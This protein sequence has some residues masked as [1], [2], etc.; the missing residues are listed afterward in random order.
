MLRDNQLLLALGNHHYE[1]TPAGHR[2]LT[3]ELMLAK[4]ASAPPEPE[5]WLQSHGWQL[6]E[7]VNERVRAALAMV[8]LSGY[9]ERGIGQLSGGQRQ[10]VAIARVILQDAPILIL[11]EATSALD[12]EAEAAECARQHHRRGHA[13]LTQG[14]ACARGR[15]PDPAA[16]V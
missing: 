1:L 13:R 3:R 4:M 9:E 2:Y 5:E 8:D 10:R 14:L 11:D 12:S 16:S 6:G 7:R 15:S